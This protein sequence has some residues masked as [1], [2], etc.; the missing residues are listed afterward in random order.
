L[1]VSAAQQYL[2]DL[3]SL[4]ESQASIVEETMEEYLPVPK[5]SPTGLPFYSNVDISL[6]TGE[7]IP[8]LLKL[9]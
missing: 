1:Q 4:E 7:V 8:S 9:L 3:H 2:D 6:G 5:Q